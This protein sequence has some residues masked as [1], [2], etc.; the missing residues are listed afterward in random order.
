M[1][2]FH[3]EVFASY[4]PLPRAYGFIV[5]AAKPEN[6]VNILLRERKSEGRMFYALRLL[7]VCDLVVLRGEQA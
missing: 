4:T 7:N 6:M 2:R 3:P 1:P 5:V